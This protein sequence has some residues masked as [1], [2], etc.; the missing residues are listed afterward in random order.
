MTVTGHKTL[1]VFDRYAIVREEDIRQATTRLAGYVA[2]QSA[3]STVVPIARAKKA[4]RR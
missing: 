3:S 4:G 1:S 2:R